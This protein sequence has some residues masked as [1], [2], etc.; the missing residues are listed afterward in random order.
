[1]DPINTTNYVLRHKS[2]HMSQLKDQV[3]ESPNGLEK[4]SSSYRSKTTSERPSDADNYTLLYDEC[5]QCMN[6]PRCSKDA[7]RATRN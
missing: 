7:Y 1:M 6:S 3:K 4:S 2:Y 5:V